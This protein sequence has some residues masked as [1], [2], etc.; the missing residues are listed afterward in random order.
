MN[1][2]P[3]PLRQKI[4]SANNRLGSENGELKKLPELTDGEMDPVVIEG[5]PINEERHFKKAV[6]DLVTTATSLSTTFASEP[7]KSGKT[8]KITLILVASWTVPALLFG[9]PRLFRIG[10]PFEV[11]NSSIWWPFF[12][13]LNM[14][15]L[16]GFIGG[17]AFLLFMFVPLRRTKISSAQMFLFALVSSFLVPYFV[18]MCLDQNPFATRNPTFISYFYLEYLVQMYG[19]NGLLGG[20]SAVCVL[21]VHA[22]IK[23]RG[24]FYLLHSSMRKQKIGIE[25]NE[26]G[27]DRT[28]EMAWRRWHGGD[29]R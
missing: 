27:G 15:G 19:L 18:G 17:L 16:F 24:A 9:I 3:D 21:L 26:P 5:A 11:F 25:W 10:F 14:F 12:L 1:I 2:F 4:S 20:L 6:A 23:E 7:M 13:S 22:F 29:G 28:A 8:A